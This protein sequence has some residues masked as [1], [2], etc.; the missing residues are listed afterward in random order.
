MKVGFIGLGIMGKPMSKNLIKAGHELVVRDFN[1][2]ASGAEVARE[3]ET[4]ITMVPNSPHVRE[5]VLG[6]DGVIKTAK[7][8]TVLIDM[9]SID[10][11]ESKSIGG[12]LAEKGIV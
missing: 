12:T 10:P 7:P 11:V 3:C 2:A 1:Q 5:A 6:K 4:I 8:G 9:S